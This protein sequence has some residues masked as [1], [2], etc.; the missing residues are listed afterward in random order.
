[1]QGVA[2]EHL[3]QYSDTLSSDLPLESNM[4]YLSSN[5]SMT[6]VSRKSFISG[7]F[8]RNKQKHAPRY[9]YMCVSSY[10]N[11]VKKCGADDDIV[12]LAILSSCRL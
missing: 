9:M 4:L 12:G 7:L 2:T 6:I 1:M 11:C 10:L 3:K 8:W 5:P